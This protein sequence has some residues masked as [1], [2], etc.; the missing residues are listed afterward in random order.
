M[1]RIILVKRRRLPDDT[2]LVDLR[3]VLDGLQFTEDEKEAFCREHFVG[4]GPIRRMTREKI[5]WLQQ[6]CDLVACDAE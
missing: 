5:A 3:D 2:F 6:V 1:A 4:E